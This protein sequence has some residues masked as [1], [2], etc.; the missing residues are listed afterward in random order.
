MIKRGLH[1]RAAALCSAVATVGLASLAVAPP[2]SA[3]TMRTL[4]LAITCETG[5]AYGLEV[6]TGSGWYFPNGSSYVS[7]NYKYFTVYIPASASLLEYQPTYCDNQPTANSQPM[8][9][10]YSYSITPGTSTINAT[11][12]VTDYSYSVGYGYS[13]LF[14]FCAINSL[15]YS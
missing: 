15:S 11:G 9:E 12:Y 4:N 6:D 8:W 10:G 14:Y 1:K 3:D 2:A 7:G 5:L 13:Y